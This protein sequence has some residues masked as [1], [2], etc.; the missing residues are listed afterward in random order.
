MLSLKMKLCGKKVLASV[1]FPSTIDFCS[2][3]ITDFEVADVTVTVTPFDLVDEQKKFDRERELEGTAPYRVA[4]EELEALAL[5]RKIAKAFIDFNIILFHGSCIGV[6]GEAFLFT[7]KSGTG[8]STHTRLWRQKF[9]ERAV[10]VND[11][12]PLIEIKDDS[13][14]V[15]GTPWNGKHRLGNNISM[16]L[17]AIC[18]LERATENSIRRVAAL[19]EFPKI[20]SQTYRT[21]DADFMKK[22]LTLLDKM[23]RLVNVYRLGCNMEAEAAEI[24]YNG[25]SNKK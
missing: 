24:S 3:Y 6:D 11:D 7:A 22:T 20:L 16:P 9:G 12:K 2:D 14:T 8:K 10:M 23:L 13:V 15:Y 18:I 17:S 25:M 1:F 19:T 5:Y 21:A 4:D